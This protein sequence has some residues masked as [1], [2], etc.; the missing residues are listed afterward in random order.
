MLRDAQGVIYGSLRRNGS[1]A[2]PTAGSKRSLGS[3]ETPGF[4]RLG[5][6][7]GLGAV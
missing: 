3:V 6:R 5:F 7:V 2:D 4:E 1:W